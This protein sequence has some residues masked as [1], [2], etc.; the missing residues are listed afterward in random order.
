MP[1]LSPHL[2]ISGQITWLTPEQGGRADGPP[3]TP[4]NTYYYGTAFVPP[5][6][7][8]DGA[9]PII[10]NVAVRDAWTSHASAGWGDVSG[11]VVDEGSV[12]ML[13]EEDR[14]VAFLTVAHVERADGATERR[15][16]LSAQAIAEIEARAAAATSGP[17]RSWWEG[18]DGLAGDSVIL[19]GADEAGGPDLYLTWDPS[20]S[21]EQR[22]AD[23]DFIAHARQDVPELAADLRELRER[24]G[25]G[26]DEEA[27]ADGDEI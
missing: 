16:P 11:P 1:V 14:L 13:I 20:T 9:A 2:P 22:L 10:V 19:T 15:R 21:E 3:R 23:Q 12:I 4:W 18:R 24:V 25:L 8:D 6:T 17:W 27:T 26:V 7:S 5:R